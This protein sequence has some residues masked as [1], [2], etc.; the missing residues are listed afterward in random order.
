M[1][2]VTYLYGFVAAGR[3]WDAPRPAGVD[4]APV[5]H[6]QV[7]ELD[8]IVSRL[9]AQ[10]FGASA[11]EERLRDLDWLAGVG[12][13][14]EGV[15]TW[16]VDRGDILPVRMLTLFSTPQALRDHVLE[17]TGQLT[18]ELEALAGRREWDLKVTCDPVL[19]RQKLG[20]LSEAVARLDEEMAA[21]APGRR[22]LLDRKREKLV[23]SEVSQA[24][25][26]LGASVVEAAA[27]HAERQLRIPPPEGAA[28]ETL[29]ANVAFL[30]QRTNE[31]ALR[32]SVAA[33]QERV[34][35][36]GGQVSLT[37]P[38]APYRFLSG[39]A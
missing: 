3:S 32:E 34:E 26:H 13:A 17:R 31:D 37:G 2:T 16:F 36:L 7:G 8:A 35:G 28:G 4:G 15:V 20:E 6:V 38:W 30:V 39:D 5:E 9:D 24:A 33:E 10:R 1:S 25:R 11:V 27:V 18:R 19:L 22:Y 12:A 14:H 29:A 21:A 23:N